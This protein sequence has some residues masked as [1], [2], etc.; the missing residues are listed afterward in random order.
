MKIASILILNGPNLNLLGSR[1]PEKYGQQSMDDYF[2]YLVSEFPQFN[3]HYFQSNDESEII[4]KIQQSKGKHQ[5]LVIN[6]AA[7]THSSIGIRDAI[8]AIGILS[9]EVHLTDLNKREPFRQKSMIRDICW[10][11]IQGFGLEGYRI[12]IARL[13]EYFHLEA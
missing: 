11:S 3:L 6:P 9:I 7:Y 4:E 8:L 10:C 2:Q 12:A 5:A 1:E 13:L